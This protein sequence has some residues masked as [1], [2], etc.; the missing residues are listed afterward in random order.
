[1][2]IID[3]E[4]AVAP[5]EKDRARA[6]AIEH[7]STSHTAPI[8]W[9]LRSIQLV[10]RARS[11][12]CMPGTKRSPPS[13][14]APRRIA[15]HSAAPRGLLALKRGWLRARMQESVRHKEASALPGRTSALHGCPQCRHKSADDGYE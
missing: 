2:P 13:Q 9:A 10:D 8:V 6:T 1:V 3:L 11:N 15:P 5:A 4:D 14:P 12:G 7:L